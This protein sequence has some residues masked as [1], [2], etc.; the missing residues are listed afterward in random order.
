M[1]GAGDQG[2]DPGSAPRKGVVASLTHFGILPYMGSLRYHSNSPLSHLQD[3]PRGF[4]PKMPGDLQ[5]HYI[6]KCPGVLMYKLQRLVYAGSSRHLDWAA[7][8]GPFTTKV[9]APRG[10]GPP[11]GCPQT[12]CVLRPHPTHTSLVTLQDLWCF[13]M[14]DVVPRGKRSM[15]PPWDHT[16]LDQHP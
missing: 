9:K 13:S 16:Q 7:W 6:P 2:G 4:L 12:R 1:H 5:G 3:H 11:R 15:N 14:L 8:G 10:A